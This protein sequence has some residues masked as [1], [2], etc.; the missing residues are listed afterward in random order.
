MENKKKKIKR[1]EDALATYKSMLNSKSFEFM[2]QA[3][4]EKIKEIS[5]E[6]EELKN[7]I[8]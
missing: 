2:H 3:A 6:I 4:R 5:E 7:D 1:L 8:F